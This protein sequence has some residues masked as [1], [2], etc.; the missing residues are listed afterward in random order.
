MP[1]LLPAPPTTST[2]VC[3]LAESS[4]RGPLETFSAQLDAFN[5]HDVDAFVDT[6][7]DN[8]V[9]H[10][11]LEQPLVGRDAI[12]AFYAPRFDD[13]QLRCTV[14]NSV[15]YENRWVVA[16]EVVWRTGTQTTTI[17]MFDIVEGKITR[18]MLMK[19]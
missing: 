7:A 18:A 17:A 16:H 14:E 9:I 10:G 13:P 8:A 4:P 12:H 2:E 19:A 5:S 11:L 1:V 6:Y 15:V 3:E